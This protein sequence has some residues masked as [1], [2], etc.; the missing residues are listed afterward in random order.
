MGISTSSCASNPYTGNGN[1]Y[2][3]PIAPTVRTLLDHLYIRASGCFVGC[4]SLTF[5]GGQFIFGV[6]A[7]TVTRPAPPY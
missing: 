5:K 2:A 3:D 1:I 7:W 6:S 4:M